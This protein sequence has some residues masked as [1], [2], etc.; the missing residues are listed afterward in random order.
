MRYGLQDDAWLL[1]GAGTLDERVETLDNMGVEL[2]RFTLDWH[3]IE[4]VRGKR[5]WGRAEAALE[6][7]RAH[8]IAPVVTLYGTP[9]WANGGR[10]PNWA[11]TSERTF[12]SFATAAAKRYPW[13]KLWLVWNEPNQ[14]RWLQPTT[15]RT[16]VT[17]LLN[18]AF[19]AIHRGAR[20]Q[21]SAAVSPPRAA[22]PAASHRSRGS[23]DGRGGR[24]LDAYAHNPYPLSRLETPWTGA[25]GHCETITMAFSSGCC[26]KC[27]VP[28][29]PSGSG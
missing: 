1:Y 24:K 8:G 17:K 19:A 18:P 2:V 26:A 25:C 28:L 10:S 3:Q 12:A 22:P 27:R 7:L 21:R 6:A 20:E 14:R 16:Y 13:V 23:V 9:R 5:E 4:K 29:V 11:P 15:P